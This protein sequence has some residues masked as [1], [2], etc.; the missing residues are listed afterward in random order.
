MLYHL[1]PVG[2]MQYVDVYEGS[3]QYSSDRLVIL[4][5]LV[6]ARP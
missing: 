2:K 4:C 5:T 6:R 1:D 3:R